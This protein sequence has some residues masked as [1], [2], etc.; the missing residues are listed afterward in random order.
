MF[1]SPITIGFMIII[2]GF[3]LLDLLNPTKTFSEFENRYLAS[4]PEVSL[5]AV[6]EGEFMK[7]Y[8]AYVNDQFILRNFWINIKSINERLLSKQENN[9]VIYGKDDYLFDKVFTIPSTTDRN[10]IYLEEFLAL[11][12]HENITS[13]V[14]PNSF[15][16]LTHL[17]PIGTPFI[18]QIGLINEW[19]ERYGLLNI[20]ETLLEHKYEEL[21]YR[22]DHHWTLYGAY[23]TYKE[24][25][26][27]WGIEPVEYET[28]ETKSVND[29]YGTYYN[30]AKPIFYPAD[31]L[32]YFEPNILYYEVFGEKHDSLIDHNAFEIN[33][34]YRAFMHGNIGFSSVVTRES[35]DP[36]KILVIKDSYANSMIPF[37]TE[38]FDQIDVI[39]L[40]HFSGSISALVAAEDYDHILFMQNFMQFTQDP[41][42]ARLRY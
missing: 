36:S 39:D 17:T 13:V 6:I 37:M 16:V 20:N 22:S 11:Y 8:E 31:T 26:V 30:R 18:D 14:I 41:T 42:L 1:K 5:E 10:L 4:R 12:E 24:I 9:G 15:S 2:T 23:L 3:A 33:D 28:F 40:R 27:S 29:F 21:Y 19:S 7:D 34:K 38:H 25:M 32:K 35:T